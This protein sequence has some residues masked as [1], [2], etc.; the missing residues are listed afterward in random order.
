MLSYKIILCKN[1]I[2]ITF[3]FHK[4][5]YEFIFKFLSQGVVTHE[6]DPEPRPTVSL[7]AAQETSKIQM[8]A[9][10]YS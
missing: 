7:R 1:W 9:P 8:L 3:V 6:S 4:Y 10:F 5:F 2:W